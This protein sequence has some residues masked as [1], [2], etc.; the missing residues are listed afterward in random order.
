MAA[1]AILEMFRQTGPYIME[2]G[3]LRRGVV[4][5]H[6]VLPGYLDNT[7]HV[8][9]WVARTFRP[10][11]VLFSLMSQYTPQPGA[12]GRLARRLTRAEYRAA[13][14]YMYN[15]GITDGFTQERTAARE[16]YTPPFDLTGV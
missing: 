12:Q 11:D 14:D 6:L 9:D 16:E 7:R 4:I 15:C 10:G 13:A 2:N 5:R 3:L 1:D 8:I